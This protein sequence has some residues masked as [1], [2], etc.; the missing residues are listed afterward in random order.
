MGE[1][2]EEGLRAACRRGRT[3]RGFRARIKCTFCV[4]C[5]LVVQNQEAQAGDHDN[6]RRRAGVGG[7]LLKLVS[8]LL[9][10]EVIC[11]AGE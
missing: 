10:G 5:H 4:R 2:G 9:G 7:Q 1:E 3:E 8:P 11:C 6:I